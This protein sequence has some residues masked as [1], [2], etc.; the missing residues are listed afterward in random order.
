M[1]VADVQEAL[2]RFRLFQGLTGTGLLDSGHRGGG[3]GSVTMN[4]VE[5][6]EMQYA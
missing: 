3:A 1:Q 4:A 2:D 6:I 5:L